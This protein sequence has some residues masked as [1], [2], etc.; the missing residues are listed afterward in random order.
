MKNLLVKERVRYGVRRADLKNSIKLLLKRRGL[1]VKSP[2]SREGRERLRSLGLEEVEY[3]L[4]ELELVD[5]II[6]ALD[7]RIFFA[8]SRDRGA[9]LLD[10]I[11][12]RP[13]HG[14]LPIHGPP[15]SGE[16]PELQARLHTHGSRPK[17][18][19]VRG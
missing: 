16:V 3:R 10:T 19:P 1:A 5:S 2:F 9:R 6:E 11:R 4:R 8:A 14:P 12:R 17:P 15:R 13:L 7:R 18:P